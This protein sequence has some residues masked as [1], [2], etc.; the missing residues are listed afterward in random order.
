MRCTFLNTRET[1]NC[2]TNYLQGLEDQKKTKTMGAVGV[3]SSGSPTPLSLPERC[4]SL[5]SG[6][7]GTGR[8]LS[9]GSDMDSPVPF[10]LQPYALSFRKKGNRYKSCQAGRSFSRLKGLLKPYLISNPPDRQ[11][12]SPPGAS[13]TCRQGLQSDLVPSA[14]NEIQSPDT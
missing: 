4:C 2:K 14:Q 13:F 11:P 12:C 8:S 1:S 6:T 5:C 9:S 10:S 3:Q 7:Q